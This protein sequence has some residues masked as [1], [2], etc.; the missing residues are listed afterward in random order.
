VRNDNN[1]L[2]G[3]IDIG[4]NLR[5]GGEGAGVSEIG[6]A[7]GGV[8]ASGGRGGRRVRA[9]TVEDKGGVGGGLDTKKRKATVARDGARGAKMA[10]RHLHGR[11]VGSAGLGGWELD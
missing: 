3:G 5:W 8:Q 6:G 4:A 1:I 9:K 2:S 11:V 7:D 10:A